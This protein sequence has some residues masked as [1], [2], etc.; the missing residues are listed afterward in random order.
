MKLAF[1]F[2]ITNTDIVSYLDGKMKFFSHP[3][4]EINEKFL[5]KLLLHAEIDL[6]QLNVIAVTGGKSSDLGD[7]FNN[8][9]IV[10]VNE[11][12]AIGYGAK[13]LYNISESN[14]LVVSCGTGTACVA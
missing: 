3:S 13:D 7:T 12:E 2:G 5:T 14:Y 11:V 9:P 8:I 4:E 6:D 10:K 1:D